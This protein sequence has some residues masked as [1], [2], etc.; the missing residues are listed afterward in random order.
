MKLSQ[1]TEGGRRS[2]LIFLHNE[3]QDWLGLTWWQKEQT[4]KE[5][6]MGN[7]YA[8]FLRFKVSVESDRD[9]PAAFETWTGASIHEA[10]LGCFNV[11]QIQFWERWKNAVREVDGV[12]AMPPPLCGMERVARDGGCRR[13]ATHFW[14]PPDGERI[15][16][17]ATCILTVVV[18]GGSL[19]PVEGC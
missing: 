7:W 17:C 2:I 18:C 6:E 3:M 8:K 14:V 11:P 9:I 10:P 16:V 4:P 13:V 1:L 19:V 5:K 12:G 15:P